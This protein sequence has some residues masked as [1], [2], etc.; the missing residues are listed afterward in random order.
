MRGLREGG[1]GR[2]SVAG[3]QHMRD[4]V[5]AFFPNRRA[6]CISRGGGRG[7]R[8]QRRVVDRD[9][10]RRVLRL[11]Q[12]LGDDQRN[13]I[14]DIAHAIDH[15][16]RPL[17]R[18]QRRAVRPLARQRRPGHA[19]PVAR[20]VRA[21]PHREHARC[22]TRRLGV[23]QPDLRMRMQRAQHDRMRLAGKIDVV[24]EAAPAAQQPR[25]LEAADRLA[26]AEL[27]QCD[28]PPFHRRAIVA[29]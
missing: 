1:L 8:G 29:D 10:L 11:G 26:D 14:A 17:R 24:D 21:R 6:A 16:G 4:V 23:D 3:L 19:E 27:R 18:E 5:G 22:P 20:I 25:I 7:H 12:A 2:R 9:Q 28:S 13:G 15:Q